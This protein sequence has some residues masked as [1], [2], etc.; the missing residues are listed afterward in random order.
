MA[1]AS[2]R[3]PHASKA[4]PLGGGTE[5]ATIRG[6]TEVT[7]IFLA[8]EASHDPN[9]LSNDKNSAEPFGDDAFV[10]LRG[11]GAPLQQGSEA[12]KTFPSMPAQGF[13]EHV[14]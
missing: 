9:I 7:T 10:H 3:G 5:A 11:P 12:C 4:G 14:W 1:T 6:G 13:E 2:C 8:T